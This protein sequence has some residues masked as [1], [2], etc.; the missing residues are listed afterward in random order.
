MSQCMTFEQLAIFEFDRVPWGY[1]PDCCT[2]GNVGPRSDI[3][4]IHCWNCN[5]IVDTTKWYRI[6][7]QKPNLHL[8]GLIAKYGYS[9]DSTW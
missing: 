7:E 6:A 8:Q 4:A 2:R 9:E 3:D 5:A 1:C